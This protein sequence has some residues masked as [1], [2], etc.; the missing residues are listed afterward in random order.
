MLKCPLCKKNLHEVFDAKTKNNSILF[1]IDDPKYKDFPR[2]HVRKCPRCHHTIGVYYL[3][4][5]DRQR[6]GLPLEH[7]CHEKIALA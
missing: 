5:K 4:V 7:E 1:D 3:T 2:N 6:L